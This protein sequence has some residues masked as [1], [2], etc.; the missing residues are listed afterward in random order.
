VTHE[1]LHQGF[2]LGCRGGVGQRLGL[3]LA[4]ALERTVPQV[5][6]PRWAESNVV[7]SPIAALAPVTR[8]DPAC[9]PS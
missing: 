2:H 1:R 9:G 5:S 4:L 6:E 3:A 8:T 7:A